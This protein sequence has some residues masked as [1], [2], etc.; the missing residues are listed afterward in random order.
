MTTFI[1]LAVLMLAVALFVLL[2]PLLRRGHADGA[3]IAED[4]S[5]LVILRGQVAELEADVTNGVITR[6]HF[7][8]ART[9]L[10]ARVLEDTRA[11]DATGTGIAPLAGAWTAAV[12][13]GVLPIAAMVLYVVL[14]N[15][16]AF[17]PGAGARAAAG[18]DE[19]EQHSPQQ[20]ADMAQKLAARLEKEPNNVEGW[21]T[22]AHTYYALKR[23]PEAVA[24]YERAEALD[25]NNADLLAD[26]ADAL[27]AVTQS[28]DGK[29]TQLI[30][31]ALKIDPQQWK[32]LA[33][34][35]TVAF[36]QKD[37]KSAIDYRER[38]KLVVPPGSEIA[39]SIDANIAEARQVGGIA[40]P[41]MGAAPAAAAPAA[42][43]MAKAAAAPAKGAD[44]AA[45]KGQAI[46]GT[47]T[48]SP[49][50]AKSAGPNDTVFIFARAAQGPKLP[51]A[52]LRKQV[53]DLPVT[54]ALDDSMAMQPEMKI[55][56]FP[57]VIVGARVSKSGNAAPQ[58]GDLEGL[59]KPVKMG[60]SGL[61]IVID[62]TRP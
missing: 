25:P 61:A 16:Q 41:A 39:N 6:E 11:S 34:M 56:N 9:E 62:T 46:A 42:A 35:G 59:S 38:L 4:A 22:L 19:S 54:F 29:P 17:T 45:A 43:P 18:A 20:V 3:G 47:V 48:L 13:A 10:E 7:E 58:A 37:F 5:N 49:A 32:A 40:A 33:L 15:H 2:A 28:L 31:R 51:L 50:L 27:G 60:A 1:V 36:N 21:V 57:E 30:T 12:L 52:V 53:K 14:G 26:Y 44:A 23:F 55:S 24:A 8:Q